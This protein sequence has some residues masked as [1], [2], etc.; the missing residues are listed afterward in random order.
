MKFLARLRQHWAVRFGVRAITLT[1]ALLMAALVASLTI[2]LGPS[3]RE[4]AERQA[5]KQLKRTVRF[6][7]LSIHLSAGRVLLE[8]F[9][10]GGVAPA[11]GRSSSPGTSR[12]GSTGL[13][14]FKRVPEF[15][16][17]SVEL[18]D[19]NM[20]VERWEDHTSFPEFVRTTTIGRRGRGGS[21]QPSSISGPGAGSSSTKITRCRGA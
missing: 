8:D 3:L 2:D 4:L 15:T 12:S 5:S 18:T 6:G 20:L 7:R 11:T 10:I 16:I 14:A 17:T 9:S 13:T 21:R 19:W 1:I